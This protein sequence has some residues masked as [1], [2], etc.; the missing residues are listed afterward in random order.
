[1]KKSHVGF[2]TTYANVI[3]ETRHSTPSSPIKK[4]EIKIKIFTISLP[5]DGG[6]VATTNY[7]GVATASRALEIST[8]S[9]RLENLQK[10]TTPKFPEF[11]KKETETKST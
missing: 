9:Q 8:E 7:E 3:G 2:H 5:G 11:K 1:M 4:M 10:L 6:G